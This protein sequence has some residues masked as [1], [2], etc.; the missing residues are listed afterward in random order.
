MTVDG[1]FAG[2]RGEIDW[3]KLMGKFISGVTLRVLKAIPIYHEP[4]KYLQSF[5][6]L[7]SAFAFAQNSEQEHSSCNFFWPK[8]Q[9]E[10]HY[11]CQ[12]CA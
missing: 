7:A 8:E 12:L 6:D 3:Y 4:D 2:P 11:T 9:E 1:F 5:N 10:V